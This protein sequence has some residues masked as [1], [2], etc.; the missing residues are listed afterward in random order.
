M[1]GVA[2]MWLLVSV[3]GAENPGFKQYEQYLSALGADGSASPGW[4]RAA[5]VVTGL[6]ILVVLPPLAVWRS[7]LGVLAGVAGFAALGMAA[8]PMTC[9]GSARFCTQTVPGQSLDIA[10]TTAVLVFVTAVISLSLAGA[11]QMAAG[12]ASRPRLWPAVPA[13]IAIV[14]L[15]GPSLLTVTGLPQ[16]M[17]LLAAQ[18]LVVALGAAA[19]SE[20]QRRHRREARSRVADLVRIDSVLWLF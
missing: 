7:L 20:L 15:I 9:P 19:A 2:L 11:R 10:H 16:R 5:L 4:G 3:G 8:W 6:A 17:L 13:A 14:V 18:V 12:S 1:A